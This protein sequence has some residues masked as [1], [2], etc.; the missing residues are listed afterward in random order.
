MRVGRRTFLA[1]HRFREASVR[2]DT[3]S[4]ALI[5]PIP[6]MSVHMGGA[7]VIATRLKVAF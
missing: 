7:G 5:G 1:I 2:A 3:R 6:V 4:G